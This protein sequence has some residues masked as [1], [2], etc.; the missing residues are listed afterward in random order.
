[1][2]KPTL[3]QEPVYYALVDVM[4]PILLADLENVLRDAGYTFPRWKIQND[5][6]SLK[7]RGLVK[8]QKRSEDQRHIWWALENAK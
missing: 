3:S 5:L 4:V 1:M 2:T 8:S 7:R 6:A